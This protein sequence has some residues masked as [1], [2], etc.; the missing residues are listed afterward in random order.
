MPTV[1]PPLPAETLNRRHDRADVPRQPVLPRILANREVE[2]TQACA[3]RNPLLRALSSFGRL[4]SRTFAVVVP[5]C[6]RLA[7]RS[8]ARETRDRLVQTLDALTAHDAG[9]AALA[10][11]PRQLW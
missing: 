6:A 5:A 4:L 7:S 2:S 11:A 3:A 1:Y 8:A 9:G 10:A